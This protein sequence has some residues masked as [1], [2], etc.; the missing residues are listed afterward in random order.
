MVEIE[1]KPTAEKI[2]KILVE[3]YEKQEGVKIEYTLVK[4]GEKENEQSRSN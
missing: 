4:K 1:N 3:L 2:F